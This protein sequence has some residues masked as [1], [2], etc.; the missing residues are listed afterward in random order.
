MAITQLQKSFTVGSYATR[1]S[2]SPLVNRF[3]RVGPA[4]TIAVMFQAERFSPG[5]RYTRRMK[6]I[7][8]LTNSAGRST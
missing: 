7:S 1:Q 2:R 8:E 3:P 4:A 5:A 6:Y